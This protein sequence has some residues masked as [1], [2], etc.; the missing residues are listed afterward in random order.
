[1]MISHVE[2][3]LPTHLPILTNKLMTRKKILVERLMKLLN[4]VVL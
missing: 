4:N 1:M 3:R 2:R